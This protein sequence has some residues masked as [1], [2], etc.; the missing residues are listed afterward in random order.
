MAVDQISIVN[1]AL[2]ALGADTI[3]SINQN[4]KSAIVMKAIY[5]LV[6]DEVQACHPWNFTLS[7]QTIAP[8]S[9]EPVHTYD[10]LYDFPNDALTLWE[11]IPHDIEYLVENRQI[12]C[13]ESS[14]DV[15]FGIQNTDESSWDAM[16]AEAMSFR[17]AAKTAYSL[18]Q[19]LELT[20]YFDNKYKETLSQARWRD[21]IEGKLLQLEADTWTNARK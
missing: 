3:S 10:F 19:S 12:V 1:S 5:S 21:S 14:L 15:I 18:A 8:I 17:L 11:V 13:N 4:T 16:F 6:R 20:Q 9:T 7:R 2:I